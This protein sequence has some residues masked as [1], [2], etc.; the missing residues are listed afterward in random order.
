MLTLYGSKGGG[1][2]ACS[3]ACGLTSR[4]RSGRPSEAITTD[5]RPRPPPPVLVHKQGKHAD[6]VV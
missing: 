1:V 4:G 5:L 3:T 6:D 2:S